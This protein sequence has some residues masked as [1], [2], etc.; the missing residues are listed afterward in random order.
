MEKADGLLEPQEIAA[1]STLVPSNDISENNETSEQEK[2][3]EERLR[4]IWRMNYREAAIFLEV[5]NLTV[6]LRI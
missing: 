1:L 2:S 3:W 4:E 5:R 6:E